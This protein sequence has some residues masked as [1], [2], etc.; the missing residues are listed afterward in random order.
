MDLYQTLRDRA[1]ADL[2]AMRTEPNDAQRARLAGKATIFA[3]F[4]HKVHEELGAPELESLVESYLN[5]AADKIKQTGLVEYERG[6]IAGL[7]AVR[8]LLRTHPE[9]ELKHD[10]TFS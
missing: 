7:N 8:K 2:Q 5:R 3:F 1:E 6:R 4:A 9:G 10:R